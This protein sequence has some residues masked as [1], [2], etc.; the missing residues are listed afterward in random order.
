MKN[1]GSKLALGILVTTLSILATLANYIGANYGSRGGSHTASARQYLADANREEGLAMQLVILDATTLDNV[2]VYNGKDDELF[3][4]FYENLSPS[5]LDSMDRGT[6]FDEQ[7]YDEMYA[8]SDELTAKADDEFAL[9]N[10]QYAKQSGLRVIT[11]ISAM[12]L[13]FAAYASLLDEENR[14]R[15]IFAAFA[16]V[17]LLLTVAQFLRVF[18]LA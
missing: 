14:L 5:L 7:Y 9:A 12:G 11:L 13:S 3:N 17:A 1:I 6:P 4:Y 2:R 16:G 15:A 18:V 10:I 8:L